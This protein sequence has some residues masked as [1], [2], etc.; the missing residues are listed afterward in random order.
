MIYP[1]IGTNKVT[2]QD[3]F[4][5]MHAIMLSSVYY[6]Q[7]IIYPNGGQKISIHLFVIMGIMIVAISIVFGLEMKDIGVNKYWNAAMF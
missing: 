2:I 3:V 7:T 5:V 6:M 1:D 4:Y